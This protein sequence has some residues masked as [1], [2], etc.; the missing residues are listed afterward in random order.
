MRANQPS[1]FLHGLM[2]VW[3]TKC[4]FSQLED[5]SKSL[6]SSTF[7]SFSK[8]YVHSNNSKILHERMQK[9]CVK[10]VHC[11]DASN[12]KRESKNSSI[13][14]ISDPSK[15]VENLQKF[16]RFPLGKT[17][18]NRFGHNSAQSARIGLRFCTLAALDQE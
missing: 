2:C 4:C 1:P 17:I 16:G 9:G 8:R 18:E 10:C 12:L 15:N 6:K 3:H 13:G 14:V 7:C 11:L 5:N